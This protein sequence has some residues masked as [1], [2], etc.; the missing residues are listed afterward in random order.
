[1]EKYGGELAAPEEPQP[2]HGE[3]GVERKDLVGEMVAAKPGY[4][5]EIQNKAKR[6]SKD[7]H[8]GHPTVTN[9]GF[10][11]EAEGEKAQV[12]TVGIACEP[13]HGIYHAGGIKG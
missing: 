8:K 11:H 4:G 12:G 1:V 7:C 6:G 13:L 10:A 5:V 3:N 2:R 9:L